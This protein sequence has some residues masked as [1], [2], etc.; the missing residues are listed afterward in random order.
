MSTKIEALVEKVRTI[1]MTPAQREE[2]RR[3]FAYGNSKIENKHISK[4][5]IAK[6]AAKIAGQHNGAKNKA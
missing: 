2:Q 6:E 1:K 4:E 3:N 5:S